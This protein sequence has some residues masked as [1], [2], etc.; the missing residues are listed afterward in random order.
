[1]Q[2]TSILGPA[3][4][5]ARPLEGQQMTLVEVRTKMVRRKISINKWLDSPSSIYSTI[6]EFTV[7]RRT[8]IRGNIIT[9][10]MVVAALTADSQPIVA[11]AA[12]AATAWVVRRMIHQ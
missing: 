11:I 4:E 10:G 8:A 2:Q 5:V 3:P 6:C 12:V 9:L 1:M 7:T